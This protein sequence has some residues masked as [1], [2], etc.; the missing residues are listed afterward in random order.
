MN[1][2]MSVSVSVSVSVNN[3][4]A[5]GRTAVRMRSMSSVSIRLGTSPEFNILLTSSS[6]DS[7]MICVSEKRKTTGLFWQP[8]SNMKDLRSSFHAVLS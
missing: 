6:I 1:V 8:A 4:L 7:L 3:A 2:N 5:R